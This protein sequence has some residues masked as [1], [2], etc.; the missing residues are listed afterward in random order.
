MVVVIYLPRSDA[1]MAPLFEE[2]R[3]IKTRPQ[4]IEITG[5]Y[6]FCDPDIELDFD[7]VLVGVQ[8]RAI[9]NHRSL[10]LIVDPGNVAVY[11]GD[12]IEALGRVGQT[13][14]AARLKSIQ[15]S[16]LSLVILD[17]NNYKVL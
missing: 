16:S 13:E 10:G 12:I 4:N 1:V 17:E 2:F 6:K 14:T 8:V 7:N 11:L 3:Y 5:D 9:F 15:A